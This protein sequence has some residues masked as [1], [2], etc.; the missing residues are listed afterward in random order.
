MQKVKNN[1]GMIFVVAI[2]VVALFLWARSPNTSF[3]FDSFPSMALILGKAFGILG[4]MLFAV[5]LILSARFKFLDN[6]FYGLNRVYIK[7]SQIG[8]WAFMLMLFHPLFLLPTY[9]DLSF[10]RM[11]S[12]FTP[13]VYT[14][15]YNFGMFS[16]YLLIILI[17][18]TLYFRPKYH[19]WKWTHKFMGLA[20]FF[21][22]LHA[23][24]IPSDTST[25]LPLRVYVL[26]VSAIALYAYI[27]HTI[28]GKYTT[29]KFK[30]IVSGVKNMGENITEVTLTPESG[31]K[32]RFLLS[33]G[34]LYL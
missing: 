20:F 7:H 19:I 24:L 15:P 33:L 29:N 23:Y 16:L 27:Y 9:T 31:V 4:M 32:R 14:W 30:Y 8:Q 11:I 6:L 21:G 12:F 17:T 10:S 22:G 13:S 5:S 3:V 26:A 28:F 2:P 18:L 34:N 1:L 25:F